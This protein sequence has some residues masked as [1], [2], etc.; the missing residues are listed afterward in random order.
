MGKTIFY[1]EI[2]MIRVDLKSIIMSETSEKCTQ[3]DFLT[4]QYFSVEVNFLKGYKG[5]QRYLAK[6]FNTYYEVH[7]ER[8]V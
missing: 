6:F 1:T 3:I 4:C 7:T 5:K 8:I 2:L